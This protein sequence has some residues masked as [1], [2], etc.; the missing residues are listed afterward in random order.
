MK[1]PFNKYTGLVEYSDGKVTVC[2]LINW[3]GNENK[4]VNKTQFNCR[5]YCIDVIVFIV[6]FLILHCYFPKLL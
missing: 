3:I 4:G 6:G 5:A 1:D 2:G